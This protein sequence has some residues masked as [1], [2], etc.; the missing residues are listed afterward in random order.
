MQADQRIGQ[1]AAAAGAVD[2]L[3]KLRV[4]ILDLVGVAAALFGVVALQLQRLADLIQFLVADARR[5]PLGRQTLDPD[6]DLVHVQHVLLGD[7]HDRDAAARFLQDV[8]LLQAADRLADRRAA[9]A[10]LL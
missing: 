4:Q 3:M 2:Q 5:R 6:A 9:H 1:R 8:L 10:E 7:A